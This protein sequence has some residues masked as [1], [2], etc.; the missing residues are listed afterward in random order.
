MYEF[1]CKMTEFL[2]TEDKVLEIIKRWSN[3]PTKKIKT[4]SENYDRILKVLYGYHPDFEEWLK[5]PELK[6]QMEMNV[7]HFIQDLIGNMKD[8]INYE[9]GHET[10]LDGENNIKNPVK[11]EVKVDERTTNSSSLDECINKLKRATEGT[12]TKPLLIQ[13]F[14]EKMPKLCSKYSDILITGESYI[15][16]YISMDVGGV[17]GLITYLERT[18]YVHEIIE[19][20]LQRVVLSNQ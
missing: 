8:H 1:H 9:Q 17:N 18:S 6:K 20:I 13:F 16:N 4:K 2:P 19:E 5:D 3:P 14:R 10:C 11:Y 12:S 15:N 7:G